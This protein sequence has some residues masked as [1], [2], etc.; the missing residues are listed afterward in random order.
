MQVGIR[1]LQASA[2]EKLA[3][4]AARSYYV[5]PMTASPESLLPRPAP[6]RPARLGLAVLTTLIDKIVGGELPA[7][8]MLPTEP[9]LCEAFGVSRTVIRESLKVLEEKGLVRVKQG[10]GTTV[11]AAEQWNLLDPL[12]LEA[13]IRHDEQL[14]ILDDLI[15]VRVGLECQMTRQAAVKM[16]DAQIAELHD[17]LAA[18]EDL[19]DDPVEYLR[20]DTEYHDMIL[21]ASGNQLGRSIIRSIHPHARGSARYDG[22]ISVKSLLASHRGHVA[23]YERLAARD[24]DGAAAA[25]QSHISNSWHDRK[26]PAP[27]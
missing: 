7:Q 20:A 27:E 10:Q 3:A 12:V 25:M 9:A 8:S 23:I 18:L 21:R 26:P 6:R 14:N 5:L 15:E 16:T 19:L 11:A 17:A 2:P 24:A 13:A 4:A 22:A 1:P